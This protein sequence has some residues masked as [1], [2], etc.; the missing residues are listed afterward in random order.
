MH[1]VTP[2]RP[3][4]EA[5]HPLLDGFLDGVPFEAMK[6]RIL[7]HEEVVPAHDQEVAPAT[8]GSL[9]REATSAYASLYSPPTSPTVSLAEAGA[10]TGAGAE[11]GAGADV[12]VGARMSTGMA[13]KVLYKGEWLSARV[14]KVEREG[15][16]P[17]PTTHV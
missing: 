11:T 16:T 13:V 6:F 3:R 8:P 15:Y 10:G 4:R 2:P 12:G 5:R 17:R 9:G 7:Q 14:G 1:T